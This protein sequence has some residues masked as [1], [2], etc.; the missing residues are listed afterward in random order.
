ME[1]MSVTPMT[2]V[3]LSWVLARTIAAAQAAPDAASLR[4]LRQ[5][6]EAHA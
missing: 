3:N 2:A 4:A 6:V 1:Q 5:P